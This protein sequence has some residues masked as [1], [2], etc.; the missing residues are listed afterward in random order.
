VEYTFG[1]GVVLGAS[2]PDRAVIV[3]LADDGNA[4]TAIMFH[5]GTFGPQGVVE[6]R[7]YDIEN[8]TGSDFSDT[9][10]GNNAKN[11]LL[12]GFGVDHL[13]GGGN[14]DVLNGG[15]DHDVLTGGAGADTFQFSDRGF[16]TN[17][18]TITD[19]QTGVDHIDFSGFYSQAFQF[20]NFHTNTLPPPTFIGDHTF[21]GAGNEL[22]AFT[23]DHGATIVQLQIPSEEFGLGN[24]SHTTPDV[25]INLGQ[26]VVHQSDF[27]F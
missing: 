3:T 23:D 13:N 11:V 4:G 16:G 18:D 20:H 8:V 17:A 27:L 12:G 1:G 22:R 7:L 21:S 25:E 5:S 2:D 6:D 19:F 10:T 9:L 26:H 15:A 24:T 14:D